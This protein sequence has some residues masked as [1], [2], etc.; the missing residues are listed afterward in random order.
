MTRLLPDPAL[1]HACT[2]FLGGHGKAGARHW[3]DR[4]AASPFLD[5]PTD[6]YSEGAAMQRLEAETA[7]LLGKEAALFFHK[8]VTAQQ[9]ALQVH[10]EATG[11]RIVALHPRSHIALDEHDTLDRLA[12]LVSRR[13]G[14]DH[15]PFTVA[16]LD[17]IAAPLGVVTVEVPLRRS[18]FL[19][20]PWDDLAAIAAWCR[21]RRVPFHLDGARIWEVAP[22]YGK[23]LADI[24]ALSDTIYVSF[25]KGLG[26]MGGCVLAGPRDFIAACKPWRIRYGG[27]MPTIF[28]YVLTALDG[29]Q[30][31]LPRM[32]EYYRHAVAIAGAIDARPGLRSFPQAPHGNS[33]RILFE[34]PVADLEAASTAVARASGTW[35]FSRFDE[36]GLPGLS[37]AE[38]A[39][40]EAT[41]GWTAE[42]AA[43]AV[44]GLL[45]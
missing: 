43:A 25:Y 14:L 39:V 26:G 2:R 24:A 23:S 36:T 7:A 6:V 8:G 38:L 17:R 9:V 45:D 29:L 4:L 10:A 21:E 32:P 11:R 3:L 30:R 41:L 16:D 35:L 22:Y 33:F 34:A 28:P 37:F 40:G 42:E 12:H 1:R 27:D 15:A 31:H 44:A 19:A 18:G 13:T 5:E 20:P